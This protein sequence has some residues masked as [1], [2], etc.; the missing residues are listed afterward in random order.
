MGISRR[1]GHPLWRARDL[2]LGVGRK[3][4]II[5]RAL[6]CNFGYF[7]AHTFH[8]LSRLILGALSLWFQENFGMHVCDF[9]VSCWLFLDLVTF[10][11]PL[12]AWLWYPGPVGCACSTFLL[13]S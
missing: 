1:C 12:E 11:T 7:G 10:A 3:L 13:R 5:Y 9:E 4:S 8:V 2:V 6:Y